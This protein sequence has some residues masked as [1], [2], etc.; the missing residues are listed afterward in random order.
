MLITHC[1]DRDPSL[2]KPSPKYK[3]AVKT[4]DGMAGKVGGMIFGRFNECN[5][6]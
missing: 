4:Y 6:G 3:S 2:R 5:G 1:W